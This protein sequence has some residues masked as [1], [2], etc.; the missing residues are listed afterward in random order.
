M[1]TDAQ[2]IA[3]K[4]CL[5]N[6]CTSNSEL[7]TL[8][9]VCKQW[10]EIAT[11]AIAS[12]AIVASRGEG[13]MENSYNTSLSTK[14]SFIRQLMITDMARELVVRKQQNEQA[15]IKGG[16]ANKDLTNKTSST[17]V[18]SQKDS[19]FC[20]AWFAPSGIQTLSVS[21]DDDDYDDDAEASGGRGRKPV[22]VNAKS[23]KKV[24]CCSEWRGYRHANEVLVPFGYSTNFISVSVYCFLVLICIH[25][26]CLGK[27]SL[28]NL[29]HI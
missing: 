22:S 3:V 1:D 2:K 15:K 17:T 11:D 8:S 7:A 18:R 6:T 24:T 16:D 27:L 20:L 14:T 21:L 23:S 13:S 5:H 25:V 29:L 10:R 28:T 12:E 19:N 26:F 4:W 9:N